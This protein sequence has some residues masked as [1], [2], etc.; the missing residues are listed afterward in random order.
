MFKTLQ[1]F[2]AFLSL[3]SCLNGALL[4]SAAA[5]YDVNAFLR[6]NDPQSLS[7]DLIIKT[8]T[9]VGNKYIGS[10]VLKNKLPF[11]VGTP[12]DTRKSS[13]AINNLYSLG[14]FKQVEIRAREEGTVVHLIIHVEEKK[15]LEDSQFIGN[16][17]V[18]TKKINE[19]LD[20][21][22]VSYID[23]ESARNIA[24]MVQQLYVAEGYHRAQVSFDFKP[25]AKNKNKVTAIFTVEEGDKSNVLRVEF[26]G[27]KKISSRKLSK[28]IFTRERWLL[29][30]GDGSGTYDERRVE[31]D[32]YFIESFYAENSFLNTKVY[33]TDVSFS[34]DKKNITIIFHIEEGQQFF[35]RSVN[36]PG[37]DIVSTEE[38]SA[39]ITVQEG[40]PLIRHELIE[41]MERMGT[42]WKEKGY[43]YTEVTETI[44]PDE[45]TKEIDLAFIVNPGKK[46]YANRIS[47]S[48]NRNT[49]DSL[50]RR[51]LDILEG[52]LITNSKLETS[53]RAVEFLSFYEQGGVNWFVHRVAEDLADLELQ[54]KETKT[55]NFNAQLSYGPSGESQQKQELQGSILLEKG[56]LLGHGIDAGLAVKGGF[57]KLRPALRRFEVRLVDPHIFDKDVSCGFYLYHR[58]DEYDRWNMLTKIPTM[59]TMGTNVRFGFGLP[60]F[61]KRLALMLDL[62]AETIRNNNPKVRDNQDSFLRNSDPLY[63]LI[64]NRTFQEGSLLWVGLDLVKD[65]RNHQVYPNKGYKITLGTK[66]AP[67]S[68]NQTFGFFRVE[69]AASM[70]NAILNDDD[71]VLGNHLKICNVHE[72][73][74][75]KSIP[76]KEL[77]HMGGPNTVRGH[78]WSGIG[79][80]W[81]A[82][83][84]PLGGRNAIQC[85]NE[86]T[87]PLARNLGMRAHVFYDL[88]AAW[89][90]PDTSIK[91]F[92]DARTA[93]ERIAFSEVVTRNKFNLRHTVGFGLNLTSPIPAKIDWG[94]KLDRDRKANESAHEFHL[95][96]NYAW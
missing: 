38:A 70:Y 88:G 79:P 35:V 72:L 80:A 54:V 25:N 61:D 58:W 63:Q 47:I 1:K 46:L 20:L 9:I 16:H 32:K 49:R 94:F 42:L 14:A 48:G 87:F 91:E 31:Q 60:E 15:L 89:D 76:Y 45:K 78:V 36:P 86:I 95:T 28:I 55:G 57:D 23:E 44:R 67:S 62:G 64:V 66:T 43:I 71:L 69:A 22:K 85:N 11:Q 18:S 19:T 82:T 30:F 52:D 5:P 90:T 41:S 12:L 75:K 68:I 26:R 81:K 51:R 73:S 7:K 50:I 77:F 34:K 59:D 3:Y 27:N 83:N 6:K 40:K 21:T 10:E 24:K 65:M 8:I 37:D 4:A 74:A 17:E 84:E 56:N 29:G 2:I 39:V 53:K 13:I 96:M 92:N 93:N 33:K